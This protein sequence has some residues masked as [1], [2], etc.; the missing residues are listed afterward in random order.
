VLRDRQRK[1]L[2]RAQR[3][4]Q[5]Q[6]PDH[7]PSPEAIEPHV[8]SDHHRWEFPVGVVLAAVLTVPG[9]SSLVETEI[10]ARNRPPR[11]RTRRKAATS[12]WED[13]RRT[14]RAP[15]IGWAFSGAHSATQIKA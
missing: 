15:G 10:A 1:T 5:I 13:P 14:R 6:D 12:S 9:P 4:V 3:V 8:P 11:P 2:P 7:A